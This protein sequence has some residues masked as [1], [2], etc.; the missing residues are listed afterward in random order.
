MKANPSQRAALEQAGFG[1][2]IALAFNQAFKAGSV[3]D[4]ARGDSAANIANIIAACS[5]QAQTWERKAGP[6]KIDDWFVRQGN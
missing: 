1:G 6:R 3:V 4:S 5:V 2:G